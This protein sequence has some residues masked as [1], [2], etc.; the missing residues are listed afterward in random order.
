MFSPLI[1]HRPRDLKKTSMERKPVSGRIADKISLFESP[2]RGHKQTFQTT[3]IADV[4]PIRKAPERMKADFVLSDQRS[5]S[6]EGHGTVRSSSTSPV[7]GKLLSIK[8]RTKNFTGA[9]IPEAKP[10]EAQTPAITGKSQK[11]P[12]PHA[13]VSVSE[14]ANLDSQGKQDT[15]EGIQ[16]AVSEITS[17]P[18]EQ[19]T[20]IAKRQQST[21]SKITN[22]V[23]SK[24]AN[25]SKKSNSGE[26]DVLVKGTDDSSEMTNSISPQSKGPSKTGSRP[27]RRKSKEPMSPVSP[28]SEN[29]PTSK[30]EVTALK[31][32][33]VDD[34]AEAVSTSKQPTGKVSSDKTHI[35]A[36]EEQL[37]SDTK[38]KIFKEESE[39]LDKPEKQIDSAFKKENIDKPIN[40]QGE[41]PANKDEPDT[42]ACNTGTKSVDKDPIVLPKKVEEVGVQGTA[43]TQEREMASKDSRETSASSPSPVVERPIEKTLTLEQEPP[44]E[45]PK[46]DRQ[47]SMQPESK[48]K[49][50]ENVRQ[51]SKKDPEQTLQSQNKDT[52]IINQTE[53]KNVEKLKKAENKKTNHIEKKDKDQPLCSNTN[54]TNGKDLDNAQDISGTQESVVK[55]D[56][57]KNAET[58]DKTQLIKDITK[59]EARQQE[60]ASQSSEGTS[61]SSDLCAQTH[62]VS[63]T[64]ATYPDRATVCAVTPSNEAVSGTEC[65]KGPLKGEAATNVPPELQTKST[66]SPRREKKH[67]VSAAEPQ[68]NSVS[69]E[70]TENSPDDSHTHGA[71]DDFSSSKPITKATTAVEEVTVKAANDT[72]VLITAQTDNMGEKESSIK[73]PTP[74]SVSKSVSSEEA[75]Q[76]DG[77]K[78]STVKS[79]PSEVKI[80]GDIITLAPSHP[81]C[82][83]SKKTVSTSD[84]TSPKGAGKIAQSLSDSSAAK[85]TADAV[86]KTAEKPY[87]PP[88]NELSPVV[89]GAIALCPQLTVK[90]EPVNK[91]PSQTPKALTSPEANKLIPDSIQHSSMKKLNFPRGLNKDDSSKREDAPSSWLDVDFPKKKL[92]VPAPKLSSSGSESNLL[93]TSGELN[94]DDFVEKIKKLCTP[95]SLPPRKHNH[96]RPPQPPFAMPA[97]KEDRFEKTFDPK[98]FKFGL[99]KN[100]QFTLDTAPSL[101]AQLQNTETK[102]GLKPAR[103]SLADRSMLLSSLD[104]HSRLREKKPVMADENKDKEEKDDQIKVKSRLEGSCVFNSLTSSSFRGERNGL[105]TQVDSTSS[106][107]VSSSEA[108]VLSPPPLSQ[109]PLS[110]PAATGPVK[111]VL[112]KQSPAPSNTEEA[113]AVEAV[114]CDSGPPLP[115]FNDI[116]LPDY[117]EK[118]LPREPVK[119]VQCIQSQEPVK[120][121]VSLSV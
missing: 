72:P 23:A 14:S 111:D 70:K 29:K 69:V 92:K 2:E 38:E 24:T 49:E 63:Q 10:T 118:Y 47:L 116:K 67:V 50:S 19:D 86:E 42:A 53:S 107:D 11:L 96:L 77:G 120:K 48:S 64:V 39:V 51:P 9:S 5:R 82:E 43:F 44:I 57:R 110:S 102:S 78:K 22:T 108:H 84:T 17:K 16:T 79:V 97:I 1:I 112:A 83:E 80:S 3:R 119:S 71:H 20:S 18:D 33:Q 58:K 60:P 6:A 66:E 65:D 25:L 34:T 4:S 88:V 115:S 31:Q 114:V 46:L 12:P 121:E 106:G 36:S 109:P 45:H 21:D 40:R 26:S 101:L 87:N 27:K 59:P 56:V 95:F 15:K 99:R 89:N 52:E 90:K 91:K 85:S 81:Q 113:Q 73:E 8:E 103:A 61:G 75:G 7:K 54:T 35:N 68:P 117:L 98:E 100:N 105:Q 13:E 94:D 28:N 104:T 37:L 41:L 93:D 30:L 76:G 32:E 55:N 62:Y 74:V